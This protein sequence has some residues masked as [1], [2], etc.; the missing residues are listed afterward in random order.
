MPPK[1]S[2]CST[3]YVLESHQI[4][5]ALYITW[6]RWRGIL[7]HVTNSH[8]WLTSEGDAPAHCEHEPLTATDKRWFVPDSPAHVTLR[9]VVLNKRFMN[10]LK[11]YVNFRHTGALEAFHNH[12]LMYAAK[13]FAFSFPVYRAR[14]FLAAIDYQK[15]KDL[16]LKTNSKGHTVYHTVFNKRGKKWT[17]VPERQPKHYKYIVNLQDT[18]I[19]A[20]IEDELP[21]ARKRGIKPDNPRNIAPN[22]ATVPAPPT[23]ELVARHRTRFRKS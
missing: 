20:C 4:G 1:C 12:I 22:I 6:G 19:C 9:C 7:H 23:S 18:I 2:K 10:T 13:R 5:T 17:I 3:L 16:P 8:A 11:Y 15:H 14:N 21:K